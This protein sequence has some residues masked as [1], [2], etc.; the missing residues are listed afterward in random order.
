M[1]EGKILWH[2]VSVVG[3]RID[4]RRVEAIQT[5]SLPRFMKEVQSFLGKIIFLRRFVSNFVELVNHII[6]MLKKGN[7][8]KWIVDPRESFNQI[9]K[10]LN[11]AHVLINPNYSKDFRVFSFALFDTVVYVLLQNN[12]VGLEKPIYFFSKALRDEEVRYDI[13]EKKA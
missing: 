5:L 11:E 6:A 3:V 9:K 8:V 13:M 7:E 12:D 2:I 1:E 4:S 10:S